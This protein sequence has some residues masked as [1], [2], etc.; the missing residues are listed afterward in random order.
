MLSV[1]ERI[2]VI[3]SALYRMGESPPSLDPSPSTSEEVKFMKYIDE[4]IDMIMGGSSSLK[5]NE[6]LLLSNLYNNFRKSGILDVYLHLNFELGDSVDSIIM[7]FLDTLSDIV[8]GSTPEES[9]Q[10][11]HVLDIRI[12]RVHFLRDLASIFSKSTYE[13]EDDNN[14]YS[15]MS[16]LLKEMKSQIFLTIA[17]VK[18][19]DIWKS[20][21]YSLDGVAYPLLSTSVNRKIALSGGGGGNYTMNTSLDSIKTSLDSIDK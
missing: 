6:L 18:G 20:H 13:D 2:L 8:V 16:D 11:L 21:I 3:N 5:E 4:F 17:E 19:G 12:G 10:L 7:D 15:D 1:S 9:L 14:R